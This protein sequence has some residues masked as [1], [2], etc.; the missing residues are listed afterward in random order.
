MYAI[1]A[2]VQGF[3]RFHALLGDLSE[4]LKVK[5]KLITQPNPHTLT[6]AQ[7]LSIHLTYRDTALIMHHSP[8]FNVKQSLNA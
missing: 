8:V 5:K 2:Y 4:I 7:F 6:K 1:I 3:L